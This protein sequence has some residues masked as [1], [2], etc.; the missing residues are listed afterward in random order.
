[1]HRREMRQIK[2]KLEQLKTS[3]RAVSVFHT[4]YFL[5]GFMHGLV[6]QSTPTFISRCC[7]HDTC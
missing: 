6:R 3:G 5:Q 1:M 7:K 4:D 2:G